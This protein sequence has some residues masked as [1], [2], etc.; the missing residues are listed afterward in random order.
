MDY[1]LELIDSV[2]TIDDGIHYEPYG[3]CYS[4]DVVYVCDSYNEKIQ[5]YTTELKL[6]NS[7]KLDCYPWHI[8]VINDIACVRIASGDFI[9]FYNLPSFTL[10]NRYHGHSGFIIVANSFFIEF[11]QPNKIYYCYNKDGLIMDKN[12]LIMKNYIILN[13]YDPIVYFNDK[14]VVAQYNKNKLIIS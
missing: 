8:K 3:I 13:S 4:N 5:T 7:F 1:E 12:H 2:D 11:C 14:F 9:S 10:K 6:I